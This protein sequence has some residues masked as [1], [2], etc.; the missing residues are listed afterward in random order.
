MLDARRKASPS[1]LTLTVSDLNV[2]ANDILAWVRAFH[3][4][5]ADTV[6]MKGEAKASAVIVGWPPRIDSATFL[7]DGADLKGPGL[8]VPVHLAKAEDHY[9]L[10]QVSLSPVK[11][12]FG[13]PAG[14]FSGRFPPR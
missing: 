8:R 3:P 7:T 13:P 12:S 2:D 11:I 10:D 4:G 5:V 14:P 6:A 1:P 9:A